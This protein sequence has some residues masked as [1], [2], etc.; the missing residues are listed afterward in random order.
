MTASAAADILRTLADAGATAI[1]SGGWAIDALVGRQTR[2]HDDLDLWL[3][4][5]DLALF[6]RA[7]TNSGLDRLYPWGDDRP[8]NFVVHDGDRRRVDL[9]LF[10]LVDAVSVH[11]GSIEDGIVFPMDALRGRGVLDGFEV[12]CESPEWALRWHTGYPIR[13]VDTHDVRVLCE[14]FDLELP[15]QYR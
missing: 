3:P 13:P 6:I 1:V 11:Y 5:A 14:H 2:R 4:A 9:H 10:E 15:E 12:D 8:W 7:F